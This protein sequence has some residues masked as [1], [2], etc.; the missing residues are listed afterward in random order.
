M[1]DKDNVQFLKKMSYR[2]RTTAL[3]NRWQSREPSLTL[4][5]TV[6]T[7]ADNNYYFKTIC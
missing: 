2:T 3:R 1:I 4:F 6:D 5:P 7:I